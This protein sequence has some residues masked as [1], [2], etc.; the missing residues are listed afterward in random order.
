MSR[1]TDLPPA[2]SASVIPT[3]HLLRHAIRYS[4]T[5]IRWRTLQL[6]AARIWTDSDTHSWIA[7]GQSGGSDCELVAHLLRNGR[8]LRPCL[9]KGEVERTI[10][11]GN[12][13]KHFVAAIP[14]VTS[15][16][17]R[18]G[19]SSTSPIGNRATGLT[20]VSRL[21]AH[22]LGAAAL[23]RRR[24]EHHSGASVRVRRRAAPRQTVHLHAVR[25]DAPVRRA[26]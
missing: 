10:P 6:Q 24:C 16:I 14:D 17:C 23:R 4:E 8:M 2:G 15:T 12:T 18:I 1:R 21:V 9:G 22:G 26:A 25:A 20:S 7:L 19:R 11:S 5:T 3:E 13:R